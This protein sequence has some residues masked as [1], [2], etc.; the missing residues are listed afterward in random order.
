MHGSA[1]VSYFIRR[2]P[3]RPRPD[4]P[5]E[6]VEVAR[7]NDGDG[8][9]TE[10][11]ISSH[12]PFVIQMAKELGGRGVPLDDLIAEGCVGILKAIRHYRAANG[13]RFMTYASFWIRKEI[14][15]AVAVQPN[16]IR[17]PDYAR[18]HG[19]GSIRSLRLDAARE[20]DG[21]H[22]LSDS[23]RHPDPLPADTIIEGERALHVRRHVLRLAPREQ[24]VIAWRFGLGGQPQQTL[25][26]I[27]YRLG[28]SRERVRQIEA[29]ALARLHRAIVRRPSPRPT[30]NLRDVE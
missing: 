12:L 23:L 4:L 13:T 6:Q 1:S 11:L 22:R 27:A 29:S 15:A 20:V 25:N 16:V 9:A 5:D 21:E 3:R 30:S 19:H 18:R 2:I 28:L 10:A 17:V 26:E 7:A 14:L 24:A 8:R